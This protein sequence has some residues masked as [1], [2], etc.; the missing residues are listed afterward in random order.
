MD[1]FDEKYKCLFFQTFSEFSLL[2]FKKF[3]P[4]A[5]YLFD[6]HLISFWFWIKNFKKYFS[7]KKL[8]FFIFH[9]VDLII[10]PLVFPYFL[11]F[12]LILWCYLASV[13]LFSSATSFF[14]FA[15]RSA[16]DVPPFPRCLSQPLQLCSLM[17][18]KPLSLHF[19]VTT[20]CHGGLPKTHAL[21]EESPATNI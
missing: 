10:L 18:S 12:L 21:E 15:I 6:F 5:T 19:Q 16:R 3:I 17:L 13:G 9:F 20:L 8:P 1:D 7:S 4:H 14:I 11:F 2:F